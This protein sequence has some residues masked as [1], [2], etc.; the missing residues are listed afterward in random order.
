MNVKK[1]LLG[2]VLVGLIVTSLPVRSFASEKP[3][4][5]GS[6]FMAQIER[7]T[8]FARALIDIV[9]PSTTYITNVPSK[10]LVSN[11]ID[12]LPAIS[13]DMLE[14]KSGRS[15]PGLVSRDMHTISSI[16]LRTSLRKEEISS[17]QLFING[18][19]QS[20]PTWRIH[21]DA[22]GP[23]QHMLDTGILFP[24]PL[25][26]NGKNMLA[27]GVMARDGRT[28]S[29]HTPFIYDNDLPTM[30]DIQ[31]STNGETFTLRDTTSGIDKVIATDGNQILATPSAIGSNRFVMQFGKINS[32]KIY[33]EVTD[34]AGNLEIFTTTGEAAPIDFALPQNALNKSISAKST[35]ITTAS[36]PSSKSSN[37]SA[38]GGCSFTKQIVVPFVY[39]DNV[40]EN[41]PQ[42]YASLLARAN[43]R[44]GLMSPLFDQNFET[45][46][47]EL[48]QAG[49]P[50]INVVTFGSSIH[51]VGFTEEEASSDLSGALSLMSNGGTSFNILHLNALEPYIHKTPDNVPIVL[52]DDFDYFYDSIS[53]FALTGHGIIFLEA[54]DYITISTHI[55][56]EVGHILGLGHWAGENNIMNKYSSSYDDII[57]Q[58]NQSFAMVAHLCGEPA[59][60][61]T[62]KGQSGDI[63]TNIYGE[64]FI[65]ANS[66]GDGYIAQNEKNAPEWC[67][68][69]LVHTWNKASGIENHCVAPLGPNGVPLWPDV[70]SCSNYCE[71]VTLGGGGGGFGS[72][73]PPP[74]SILNPPTNPPATGG[75]PKTLPPPTSGVTSCSGNV[76]CAKGAKCVFSASGAKCESCKT[77]PD[78]C[79]SGIK[80]KT[81]MCPDG[82]QIKYLLTCNHCSYKGKEPDCAAIQPK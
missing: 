52:V 70:T 47:Q 20:L 23:G 2:C 33:Y 54:K 22:L 27:V 28:A 65:Y 8:F 53:G 61:V 78:Q 37:E 40:P 32:K 11:T 76:D 34:K 56:H 67:E 41:D 55:A 77:P 51:V 35:V 3:I 24:N 10:K 46:N 79:E 82:T 66:C 75:I 21:E 60:K 29:I 15:Y 30:G 36:L 5:D 62:F 9:I 17:L 12:R 44:A 74:P 14:P 68:E 59:S 49:Q 81:K 16:R 50:S 63:G 80:E 13:L 1:I 4:F 43:K 6:F 38:S 26:T 71:C 64:L 73:D 58:S 19:P 72:G 25:F 45:I 39:K 31:K 18:I 57:L 48:N 42:S 7:I 69:S